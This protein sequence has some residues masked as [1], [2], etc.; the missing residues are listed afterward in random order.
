VEV[1]RTFSLFEKPV[2]GGWTLRKLIRSGG[3]PG[4]ASACDEHALEHQP[5]GRK[6]AARAWEWA[7]LDGERL[8]WA[9]A[10]K[11]FAARLGEEELSAA[12]ELGD[13]NDLRFERLEAPY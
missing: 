13:F 5:T 7:D 1:T 6:I 12:V 2:P 11:L 8:V 4:K 9:E 10:G 3:A